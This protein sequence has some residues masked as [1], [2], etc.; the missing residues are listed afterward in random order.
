MADTVSGKSGQR[1]TS[2]AATAY[3]SVN[4]VAPIPRRGTMERI[5]LGWDQL[6]KLE[7]AKS[8]NA[9]RIFA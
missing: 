1:V 8:L 7:N 2:C 6:P 5:A 3:K 9:V 4:A